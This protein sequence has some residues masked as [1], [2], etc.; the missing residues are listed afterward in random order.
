MVDH[1]SGESSQFVVGGVIIFDGQVSPRKAEAEAIA[2]LEGAIQTAADNTL[3]SCR[4]VKRFTIQGPQGDLFVAQ[5]GANIK[6]RVPTVEAV[7]KA[8]VLDVFVIAGCIVELPADGEWSV[9]A[10]EASRNSWVPYA[11]IP[12]ASS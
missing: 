2:D 8:G 5:A 9:A 6:D 12:A 4:E 1:T 7:A 3:V 11:S 10:I